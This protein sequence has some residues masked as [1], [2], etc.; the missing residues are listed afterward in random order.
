MPAKAQ[1]S[2]VYG[3]VPC[4]RRV[5]QYVFDRRIQVREATKKHFQPLDVIRVAIGTAALN[6]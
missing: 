4:T 5:D 1:T 3:Q 6:K 2:L